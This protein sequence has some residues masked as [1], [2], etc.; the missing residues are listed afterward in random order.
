MAEAVATDILRV[1]DG[2]PPLHPVNQ[3][4]NARRSR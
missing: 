3:P 2:Q 1:L 4:L